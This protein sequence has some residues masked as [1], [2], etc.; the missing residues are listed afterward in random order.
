MED[1]VEA[2]IV[3]ADIIARKQQRDLL[4]SLKEVA[5]IL[6]ALQLGEIHELSES[7]KDYVT[8]C[9]EVLDKLK[10]AGDL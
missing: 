1:R 5:K 8:V 10:R 6:Q 4:D 3:K 9:E 2:S 7:E